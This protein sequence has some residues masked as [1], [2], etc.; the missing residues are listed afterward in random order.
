MVAAKQK[1]YF[2]SRE[3]ADLLDVAVSTIQSWTD[4][5]LLQAWTTVGGHRR[6]SKKSVADMLSQNKSK[7]NLSKQE[8][9]VSIVIVEDN[10]Q[11][12]MIYQQNLESWDIKTN[13]HV[14][15]DGFS[16]LI[17]IGKFTPDIIITDL[18]M[19]NMNGFEMIKAI[20]EN[21]DLRY[22]HIIAVTALTTDEIKLRGSLPADVSVLNKPLIFNDVENL[23]CNQLSIESKNRV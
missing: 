7:S 11:E 5:G 6:I 14:S 22:C 3:A 18:L 13:I 19:P 9:T 10:E 4:N 1:D 20:K 21:D 15:K 12:L 17:N 2:S 16:G 8:K 23:I